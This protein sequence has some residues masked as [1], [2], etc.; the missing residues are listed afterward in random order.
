VGQALQGAPHLAAAARRIPAE[1]GR[2]R[3]VLESGIASAGDVRP[4]DGEGLGL[5]IAMILDQYRGEI[6]GAYEKQGASAKYGAP[7]PPRRGRRQSCRVA[8]ELSDIVGRLIELPE[9]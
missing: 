5:W 8:Q 3:R 6:I 9:M 7:W 1:V 2:C 4:I